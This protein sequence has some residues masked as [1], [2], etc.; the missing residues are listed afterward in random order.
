MLHSNGNHNF[1]CSV[2]TFRSTLVAQTLT[3]KS[4]RHSV[5]W[6]RVKIGYLKKSRSIDNVGCLRNFCDNIQFSSNFPCRYNGLLCKIFLKIRE[7]LPFLNIIK[8]FK[9]NMGVYIKWVFVK[10]GG[11]EGSHCET[12][13]VNFMAWVLCIWPPLP[14]V[15]HEPP[16]FTDN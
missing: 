12:P 9:L 15:L 10:A 5:Q 6:Q 14:P 1:L 16:V 8:K 13:E 2:V 3:S 4:Q 7:H 11:T